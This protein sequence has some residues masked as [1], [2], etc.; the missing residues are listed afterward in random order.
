[1][2]G[3]AVTALATTHRPA[4][5]SRQAAGL[6]GRRVDPADGASPLHGAGQTAAELQ[7]RR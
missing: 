2:T 6:V 4:E 3:G 5:A 7:R 1:M